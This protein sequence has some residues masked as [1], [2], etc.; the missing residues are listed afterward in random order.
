MHH[1]DNRSR[2]QEYMRIHAIQTLHRHGFLIH[3]VPIIR[4]VEG[5]LSNSFSYFIENRRIQH[6][7]LFR[8]IF[9][10]DGHKNSTGSGFLV[11]T[12]KL[13]V[14]PVQCLG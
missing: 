11:Q 10:L 8:P 12:G 1:T 9:V 4:P 6:S 5:D 14:K 13:L 7:R 2:A 3:A